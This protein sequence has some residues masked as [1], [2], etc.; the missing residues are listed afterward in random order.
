MQSVPPEEFCG[1]TRD[2]QREGKRRAEADLLKA[3]ELEI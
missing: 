2:E 1:A 3:R